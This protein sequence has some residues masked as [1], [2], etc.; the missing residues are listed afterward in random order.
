MNLYAIVE[1]IYETFKSYLDNTRTI[2]LHPNSR[3]RSVLLAHLLNS[4]DYKTFY[5]ALGPD[6]ISVPSF[7]DGITHDIANQNPMFG[8]HINMLEPEDY[9]NLGK[10]LDTFIQDLADL[11]PEPYILILDE[12]DRSDVADDIQWF[13]ERTI[14]RMP[15]HCRIVI[16]SRTLPRL[17]WVSMIA[18]GRALI[19]ED[20]KL[21]HENFYD[22]QGHGRQT[23]EVYAL[24]PGFVLFNDKPID[25]WEGHLP[26]LLFFFALDRPVITRSEIC[27]AFWP[28]LDTDQAVNVFHVTKRRLHKALDMDVLVHLDGYYR[29]NP[30]LDIDYDVMHFAS[31]LMD[32]R[33]RNNPNRI[34]AFQKS[35]DLYRGPFLQGHSD[36]WIL[37][38][39]VDFQ[40][41]YLEALNEM[42][43]HR[44][45]EG[46]PEHALG[47]YQRA[48][49]EN[50][51]REDIHREIMKLYTR[52][53][54]RSE[55]AAHY[56]RMTQELNNKLAPETRALYE[57]IMA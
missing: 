1:Q 42:A 16:N 30:E 6:D 19:L 54:R 47:L 28:E 20:S 50:M 11:S 22:I 13:I 29:I 33:D 43:Q 57:E 44:L 31:R 7:L 35:I 52:L 49:N 56:Q 40:A 25:T 18:Q 4:S 9:N 39:R 51:N 21:I 2:L 48:V 14:A 37:D 23:L 5:Y 12:Y 36:R 46:R 24:G 17:P 38:R 10:L 32:G 45:A 55:A 26:R 41:G 53:G 15:A 8:R 27:E 34:A 3:F